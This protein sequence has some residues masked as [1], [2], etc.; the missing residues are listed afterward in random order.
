M[1]LDWMGNPAEPNAETS[2][3]VRFDIEQS[4]EDRWWAFKNDMPVGIYDSLSKAKERCESLAEG[5]AQ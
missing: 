2:D 3:G 5:N 1:K 4:S